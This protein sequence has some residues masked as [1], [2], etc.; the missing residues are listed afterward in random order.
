[1]EEVYMSLKVMGAGMAG[2]FATL[3]ILYVF[4]VLLVK[5]FPMKKPQDTTKD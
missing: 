3:S 4:I 1:M 5:T 2:I